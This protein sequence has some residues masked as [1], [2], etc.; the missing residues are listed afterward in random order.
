LGRQ[1][2]ARR[3]QRVEKA[4]VLSSSRI[5]GDRTVTLAMPIKHVPLP[6][7]QRVGGVSERAGAKA[8]GIPPSAWLLRVS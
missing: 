2:Q 5:A 1:S 3:V 7:G 8:G 6:W 4:S